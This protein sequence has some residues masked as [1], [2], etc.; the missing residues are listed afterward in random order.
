MVCEGCRRTTS[1][2]AKATTSTGSPA[3]ARPIRTPSTLDAQVQ[4]LLAGPT[5]DEQDAGYSSALSGATPVTRVRQTGD[6]ADITVGDGLAAG[7]RNDEILAF[8]QLVCS[9]VPRADIDRVSFFAPDD[10][11]LGVPRADASL[12]QAPLTLD[13]YASLI[14][15]RLTPGTSRRLLT[16]GRD[17][18]ADSPRPGSPPPQTRRT[19][20]PSLEYCQSATW[21]TILPRRLAVSSAS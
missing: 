21:M 12:S 20:D 8:G 1:R 11:R 4:L 19:H 7:G 18:P 14:A 6:E 9:L 15:S 10:R 16:G 3:V 17:G 5:H 2:L 13:D